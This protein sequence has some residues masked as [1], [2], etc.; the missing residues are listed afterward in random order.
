MT[1]TATQDR[2]AG[3]L[4]IAS[5]VVA[6]LLANSPAAHAFHAFVH[7]SIGPAVARVGQ[8]SVHG[9]VADGAMA[10]FFLLVGLEVKREWL[11]GRLAA[12]NPAAC[13]SLPPPPG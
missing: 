2:R 6:M 10:L 4:L 13:R 12:P 11:E 3:Q 9:A 7:T 8:F 5:A 1:D